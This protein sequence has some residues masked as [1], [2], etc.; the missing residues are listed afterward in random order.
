MTHGHPDHW[1][2]VT[3]YSHRNPC[4][5]GS[6]S[7]RSTSHRDARKRKLLSRKYHYLW[8]RWRSYLY[9]FQGWWKTY[10]HILQW[11]LSVTQGCNHQ[12]GRPHIF[13]KSWNWSHGTPS[14]WN[15]VSC[16][17]QWDHKRNFHYFSTTHQKY[18]PDEW[19]FTKKKI[20]GNVPFVQAQ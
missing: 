15:Q 2:T 7:E 18:D 12:Y 11:D 4:I 20:T 6:I 10:L 9:P 17:I 8:Q 3:Y 14:C 16:W 1:D 5:M 19:A 13:W